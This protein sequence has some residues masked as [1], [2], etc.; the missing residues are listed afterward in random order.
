MIFIINQFLY[1]LYNIRSSSMLTC[2]WRNRIINL[3]I[4]SSLV[5]CTIA[6]SDLESIKLKDRANLIIY[7]LYLIN[8]MSLVCFIKLL[9]SVV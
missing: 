5:N 9:N 4:P 7:K 3:W 8:I 6:P 1:A 2:F